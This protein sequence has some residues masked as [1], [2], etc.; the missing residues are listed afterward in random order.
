MRES[1]RACFAQQ[2]RS[3]RD[4]AQ[5]VSIT[6]ALTLLQS[7]RTGGYHICLTFDDSCLGAYQH[8]FPILAEACVPAV[9]FVVPAWMDQPRAGGFD[10]DACRRLVQAGMAV[11][12]HS[13]GH[14]RLADL[15]D[16]DALSELT[17]SRARIEAELGQPCA[18]F[19]CPW[20]QPDVDYRPERDFGL[21][22]LAGYRSFLTTI[23]RHAAIGADPFGLPRVRMEPGWGSAELRYALLR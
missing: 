2:L 18:H 23:A 22:R 1:E 16:A 6:D 13:H 10:W 17:M 9:F 14:R 8:A 21:A 7:G 15:S 19:A 20:G 4:I 3:L 12:S 5:L 11:G